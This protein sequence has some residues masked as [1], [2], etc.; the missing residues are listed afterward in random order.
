[1]KTKMIF[2]LIQLLYTL[3]TILPVSILS[4]YSSKIIENVLRLHCYNFKKSIFFCFVSSSCLV[5]PVPVKL[6][7]YLIQKYSI[8][9][10]YEIVLNCN[11]KI[12][13]CLTPHHKFQTP[14]LYW[15]YEASCLYL[16]FVF[17]WG[18]W[19]GACYYIEVFSQ[20]Y[21]LQFIKVFKG[22]VSRDFLS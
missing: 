19:N 12:I 4:Y 17:S 6:M 11:N 22:T 1:M 7:T 21:K 3:L 9:I 2:A 5:L 14:W 10:Q 8:S 16:V 20:Q 13:Q 15:S 18:T